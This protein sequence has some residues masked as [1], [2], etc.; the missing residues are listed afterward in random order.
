MRE[1]IDRELTPVA[2]SL[3]AEARSAVILPGGQ[4]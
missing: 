4:G 3:N 2:Y 1:A